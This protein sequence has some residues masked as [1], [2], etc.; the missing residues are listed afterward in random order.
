MG[1]VKDTVVAIAAG[2]AAT[3]AMEQAGMK[4]MA[5]EPEHDRERE[6][7]VRPGPPFVL[8][9]EHLASRVLGMDLDDEQRQKAGMAFHY[10]AGLAWAPVY[11]LL[12]RRAGLGSVA[13]GLATGAS[14]SLI[15]DEVITPAIGASAPNRDYPAS[16]HLRGLGAHLAFGLV[17]AA[18]T[19]LGWRVLRADDGGDR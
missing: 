13:A 7:Q 1:L 11:Q 12:R 2:Y 17:V 9:A 19:E 5:L 3:K 10:G 15:L 4:L 18:V 6:Q 8:A 16:T 14:Q